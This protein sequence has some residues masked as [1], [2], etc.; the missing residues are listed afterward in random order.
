MEPILIGTYDY[1]LVALSVVI[2]VFAAYAALD[3]AGRVTASRGPAR[4]IWLGGGA[5]V[6]GLGI[7]SMHYTGMEAFRL[8]VLVEYDWPMVL[9]SMVAA[10]SASAV[11][12]F[13]VSRRTMGIA[14]AALGSLL[15][16]GGIAAMHYIGMEAMRLPAMCAYSPAIVAASVV[17]AIVIS[18]VA[19]SFAFALRGQTATWTW[20]KSG[21]AFIMGLAIPIMHY[22][23]MAAVTFMPAEPSPSDFR[24]AVNIPVVGVVGVGFATLLILAFV[25]IA[26][27]LD[28]QLSFEVRERELADQHYRM[29]A[30]VDLE[31]ERAA[32][33]EAENRAKSQFLA[34]MSHEIRTPMNG[35]IGMGGLLLESDLDSIQRKRVRTL[36]D[37]AEALLCILN[38]VLDCSRMEAGKMELETTDF[39]LKLL[40]E[41]ITD[42]LAA[43]AHAKSLGLTWSIEPDVP[44]QLRGDS[45]RLRQVLMNLVGNGLK[46]THQ[47]TVN[48]RIKLGTGDQRGTVRFDVKD[49]GIGI[50]PEKHSG[51]FERFSQADSSTARSYGGSGLG[52]SIVRGLV[53]MMG[54]ETGLESELGKGSNFWFTAVLPPQP[55]ALT[56]PQRKLLVVEDNPVNQEVAIGLLDQLGYS[57]DVV[58]DAPSAI[59]ALSQT[60][61]SLVL[62]D[63]GLPE[64]DG[65]ELSRM[66]R[67]PS[68]GIVNHGIPIIAVTANA[69]AGDREKC[70][71]AGM[72]DYISKPLRASLLGEI[73]ARWLDPHALDI[74]QR[75]RYETAERSANPVTAIRL[76]ER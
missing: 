15:M 61:Y 18:F 48:I 39:D 75:S 37:S 29:M 76:A 21:S 38:D 7:W 12:L 35:I 9:L 55:G 40:V 34:T 57:A 8:P 13:V 70:L 64:I 66:I 1:R 26:S 5:I 27:F 58:G 6:M 68:T 20:R 41:G 30:Q 19:L 56:A 47:G 22:V 51:L 67:D 52:L 16:G 62:T 63:C 32:I 43:N 11:A 44:T 71:A 45:T 72:D 74:R 2:A 46:F 25:F 33:A 24:H 4:Y 59:R 73:V 53:S 28:R 60:D 54:G 17:V 10:V 42:L 65:Y 36:I 50:A 14:A 49:T 31:R 23:G 3:L 69:L